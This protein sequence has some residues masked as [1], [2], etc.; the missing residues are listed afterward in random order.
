MIKM[1]KQKEDGSTIVKEAFVLEKDDSDPPSPTR[2]AKKK[3]NVTVKQVTVKSKESPPPKTVM[4][5]AKAAA[6]A[7]PSVKVKRD[8]KR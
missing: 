5:K 6:A 3:E 7:I 2:V 4:P 1:T 8:V